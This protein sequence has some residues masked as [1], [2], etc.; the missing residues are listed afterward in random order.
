M[1]SKI[2]INAVDPEECRIAKVKDSKLEEFHIETAS[3][4]MTKGN[5][6]KGIITRVE[7]SLQAVFIDYGVERHGFLQK[8]EIHSD[9]FLDNTSGDRSLKKL[10]RR[11]QELIVQI[12]KDPVMKKGAMLTTFVSIP[13][14]HIV[15]MPGGKNK[16]ISRKIED[17]DERKRLKDVVSGLNLPKG[18]GIIVRTAGEKST[19]ALLD[20]D[21]KYLLRLW[22]NIT[23]KGMEEKAPFLLYRERNLAIRSIRDYFASDTTE[24]LIDD[25]ELFKEVKKFI[26]IISSRHTRI[27]KQYHSDKPIFSKYQLEEQ[28]TSIFKSRVKLKSGGTIVLDQTEALVA[29]DV[30]SGKSTSNKTIEETAFQTNIEAAEEIARQLRLRDLGGLIVIDFIDMKDPKH[31]SKIENV[32]KAQLKNDKAKTRVGR[33][34]R[35][36]LMEMSRQRIRP[37]IEAGSFVTCNRCRGKGLIQS[38]EAF[39]IG[40][41]RKLRLET[42]K[43]D[44]SIVHGV[45]PGD[46][47]TY[48]LNN[49]RSELLDLEVRRGVQIII[50]GDSNMI[51]GDSRIESE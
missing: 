12:T 23:K 33:I 22:K 7:P 42:L 6:Y 17:E 44:V 11:G 48:L 45:V 21:Q 1:S 46:V 47:A 50:K 43:A 25:E 20:K 39:G 14:R 29:I 41:I 13:G 18:F 9:Y 10:V 19:K 24:I 30:N 38:L 2:L 4:A 37:S 16:G 51:P 49:K 35:F 8:N 34:S 15:L 5:I 27:V 3:Q 36:G 28:I 26:K 40:F 32:V 31:K